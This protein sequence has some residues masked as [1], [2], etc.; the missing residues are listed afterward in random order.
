GGR[1]GPLERDRA[2]DV[3]GL[4]AA[5]RRA[6]ASAVA[7]ALLLSGCGGSSDYRVDAIFDNASFLTPNTDVRIAG[8]KVGTVVGLAVTRDHKARIELSV[9][10]R[11]AP[12]H[13]DADCTIEPQSLIGERF[14]NCTPGTPAAPALR[15]PRRGGT[16]ILP[17][18]DTHSPVD[19]DLVLG[20][21]R[22]PVRERLSLLLDALGA[23]LAGHGDDLG[24]TIRRS[25]PALEQTRR[26]LA[27]LD[28]DRARL[29]ALIGD[30]DTVLRSLAA[31][32]GRIAAFVRSAGHVAATT[33][34]RRA[35][36]AAAVRRLPGLLAQAR[37]GFAQ[38]ESFAHAATPLAQSLR[39]AAP[40]VTAVIDEIPPFARQATPTVQRLGTTA[41]RA[42]PAVRA[43]AP[44]VTRLRTFA[45]SALPASQ[46]L[47]SLGQ[48]LRG[49]GVV[50]G[51]QTI[52]YY[53]ATV[54]ARFDAHS[55]IL[56]SY[57]LN[58]LCAVYAT[59]PSGDC[60]AH[61][62]SWRA[63]APKARRKRAS[64]PAAGPAPARPQK[65]ALPQIPQ[66]PKLPPVKVPKLPPLPQL[67]P[68]PSV[69][70]VTTPRIPGLPPIG[71]P[72][73]REQGSLTGLLDYLLG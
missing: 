13:A 47:D 44:Q 17:V 30:S 43:L 20:I 32:R 64:A 19:L 5:V 57:P 16:P 33:G 62:A 42:L 40:G 9:D 71:L 67:P 8:A 39:A 68:V 27:V 52:I 22:Q 7:G 11:F 63:P 24:A 69:P 38:L 53:S 29:Q 2:A 34:V 55:H 26:V 37:P 54:L 48:S 46:L 28:G 66:I 1:A 35:Q 49:E 15:A 70:P 73:L 25:A 12:F 36:L 6:L 3:Q 65:P 31:G 51:L 21:F 4:A 45:A 41:R 18:A 56:P 61:F 72:K 50:E 10:P 59:T 58:L 60:S 23:G 14:V